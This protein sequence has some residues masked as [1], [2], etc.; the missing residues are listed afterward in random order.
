M[1]YI[2]DASGSMRGRI[3]GR[4]LREQ[5]YKLVIHVDSKQEIVMLG[6]WEPQPLPPG[7]TAWTGG[8][9]NTAAGT[10]PLR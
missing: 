7:V 1:L 9:W 3:N 2:L 6:T 5:G 8:M 4:R 10:Q